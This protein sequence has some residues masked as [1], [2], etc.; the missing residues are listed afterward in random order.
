VEINELKDGMVR[1]KNRDGIMN[2]A[3]MIV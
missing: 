2:S 1:L 3:V